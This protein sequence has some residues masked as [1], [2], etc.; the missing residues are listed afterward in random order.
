MIDIQQISNI[1]VVIPFDAHCA[2]CLKLAGIAARE[3]D[4]HGI[5]LSHAQL[6]EVKFQFKKAERRRHGQEVTR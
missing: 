3:G 4:S 5:C 6:E 2:W 1:T